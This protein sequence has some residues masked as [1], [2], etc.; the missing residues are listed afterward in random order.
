MDQADRLRKMAGI[1]RQP[2][3][4][5]VLSGKGGVGKTNMAVSMAL[6]GRKR[7]EQVLLWDC[8][9]GLANCDILLDLESDYTIADVVQG[10]AELAQAI[11]RE[12]SGIDV[13]PGGSG[14]QEPFKGKDGRAFPM[15]NL[16][17]DLKARYE[18]ILV[19]CAAGIGESVINLALGA[20]IVL[21]ITNPEVPAVADAYATVKVLYQSGRSEGIKL[22]VNRAVG[23]VE[24]EKAGGRIVQVAKRFLGVE[25]D[26]VGWVPD[27]SAVARAVS[28]RQP[29]LHGAPDCPAATSLRRVW[30]RLVPEE[31]AISM[32]GMA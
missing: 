26:M 6:L 7:Y 15:V 21:L 16:L 4:I 22:L 20:D 32:G 28:R 1:R 25:I 11:V 31:A 9:F 29:F 14:I 12:P 8:D 27:D 3:V 10:R 13:L 30:G 24:A 19:D 5:A 18:L 23:P 17:A 2:L